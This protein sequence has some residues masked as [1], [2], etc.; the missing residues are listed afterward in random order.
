M[1][2]IDT[3]EERYLRGQ[4]H[5]LSSATAYMVREDFQSSLSYAERALQWLPGGECGARSTA[6]GLTP[7]PTDPDGH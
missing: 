1:G 6:L 3:D 4:I 2:Q 7:P 5:A